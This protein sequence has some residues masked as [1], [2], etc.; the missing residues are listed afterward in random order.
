[1]FFNIRLSICNIQHL[2]FASEARPKAPPPVA[3]AAP[4]AAAA[5]P[6]AAAPVAEAPVAAAPVA[7]EA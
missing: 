7:A 1:M 2:R 4:V 5:A 6:V 3:V